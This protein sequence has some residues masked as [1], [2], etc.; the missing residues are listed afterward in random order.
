MKK[1]TEDLECFYMKYVKVSYDLLSSSIYSRVTSLKKS[2]SRVKKKTKKKP[3]F[4]RERDE[5][6]SILGARARARSTLSID[7]CC[8]IKSLLSVSSYRG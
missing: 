2:P 5:I 7:A 1:K 8:G 3:D 6:K 4:A